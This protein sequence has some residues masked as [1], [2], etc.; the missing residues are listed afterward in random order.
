MTEEQK[1]SAFVGVARETLLQ[2]RDVTGYIDSETT[3]EVADG[4]AYV[5]A[6]IWVPDT[7]IDAPVAGNRQGVLE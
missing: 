5:R 6:Y 7:A 1:V 4:G 3:V 2:S